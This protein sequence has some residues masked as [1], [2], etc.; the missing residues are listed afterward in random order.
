M[1]PRT[2][3]AAVGKSTDRITRMARTKNTMNLRLPAFFSAA[4]G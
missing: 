4:D 1:M 3:K 2:V